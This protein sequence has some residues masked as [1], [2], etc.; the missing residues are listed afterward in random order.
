MSRLITLLF[1]G[2]SLGMIYALIALGFAIVFKSSRVF[3]LAHGEFVLLAAYVV[4]ALRNDVPYVVAILAALVVLVAVAVVVEWSVLR[5]LVGRPAYAVVMATLGIGII[6]RAIVSMIWGF[7]DKG[8][9]DPIGPGVFRFGDIVIARAGVATI[10]TSLVLLA[11]LGYFYQ[12]T[13]AGLAMRAI[14]SNPE[15]ALLQGINVRRMF[16][17]AWGIAGAMAVAGGVFLGAF[18]RQTGLAMSLVALHA[19][20]AI[21]IGGFDSLKG[22]VIGGVIVGLVQVMCAGYLSHIGHG[23]LQDAAP[24]IVMVVVLIIRP[25]GLFGSPEIERI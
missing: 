1:A 23:R 13:A 8:F 3:N 25:H 21:I 16:V 11:L 17:L 19:L 9:A 10:V 2:L 24:Y 18:P 5:R 14:A 7:N 20:P 6:V 22:A 4:V 15:A 12:S